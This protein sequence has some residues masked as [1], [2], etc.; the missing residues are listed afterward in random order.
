MY[1]TSTAVIMTAIVA[2]SFS[3]VR[4]QVDL[5][6]DRVVLSPSEKVEEKEEEKSSRA[7]DRQRKREKKERE[8]AAPDRR[9][10]PYRIVS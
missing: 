3:W 8:S 4:Y 5:R 10:P 1:D 2:I 6:Q 7:R 9:V